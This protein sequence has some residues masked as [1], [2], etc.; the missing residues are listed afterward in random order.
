MINQIAKRLNRKDKQRGFTLVELAIVIV[1]IA[2]ERSKAGEA[3][4]Y[5]ASIRAAQERYHARSGSYAVLV[6][7]LDVS[8]GTPKYFTIA[9]PVAGVCAD[10][11]ACWTMTLTRAGA[12]AGF[13]AYTVA[14]SE[15]GYVNDPL[16]STIEAIPAINPIS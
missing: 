10:I 6:A 4:A 11:E 13:G 8:M 5:L 1:I 12:A 3:F 7:D 9:E 16:V 14:W 15:E 2:V